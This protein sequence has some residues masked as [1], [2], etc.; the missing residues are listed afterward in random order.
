MSYVKEYLMQLYLTIPEVIT[1]EECDT[2]IE[3]G[4]ALDQIKGR[5]ESEN[6]SNYRIS[7]VA[8]FNRVDDYDITNM[9]AECANIYCRKIMNLDTTYIND[10]QFTTYHGTNQG[11]YD[12]H[13]DLLLQNPYPYD[14]K[15][16]FILQLSNPEEYT[17]GDLEFQDPFP[18][19]NDPAANKKGSVILFPSFAPHRVT[20][21]TEGVRRS[22]VSWVEGPKFR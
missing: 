14:R 4:I 1:H 20:P 8:W 2:I 11:K 21:V 12:W 17:G 13:F 22:L 7:D 19:L 3:R 5:T 6:D 18:P 10:I 15:V 9:I 16:S